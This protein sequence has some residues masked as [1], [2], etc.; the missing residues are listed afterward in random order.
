[1]IAAVSIG[2]QKPR[3]VHTAW[4]AVGSSAS[5]S[6]VGPLPAT[7]NTWNAN[8]RRHDRESAR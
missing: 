8:P 7:K 4:V 1:M 5:I 2:R 3:T 6:N